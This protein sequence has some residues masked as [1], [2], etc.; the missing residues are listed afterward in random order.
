MEGSGEPPPPMMHPHDFAEGQDGHYGVYTT[1]FDEEVDAADLA[2]GF[3]LQ[4]LRNMLDQQLMTH[5]TI[6]TKLANRLQRKVMARQMR[7]WEFDL[8]EGILDA[9][10]LAQVVAN[11]NVPL[12][13]KQERDMP[14]R[15]TVVTILIDNSGSMRGRPIALSL[16]HI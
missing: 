12:T 8:E 2:D 11:P 1:Q 14:F 3:E 5:Q 9:S 16:I 13:F 10:K 4:R 7:S 6:I 15:D